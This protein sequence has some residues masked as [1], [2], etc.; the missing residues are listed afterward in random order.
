MGERAT[1]GVLGAE[2]LRGAVDVLRAIE[3]LPSDATGVMGFGERGTIL[4][5]AGRICWAVAPGM[6]R[7]LTELLRQQRN[8]PI[9]RSLLRQL[10][11]QCERTKQP[12]GE[13]LLAGGHITE[14]GLRAALFRQTE[15]AIAHIGL[16]G[17][18]RPRFIP[19]TKAGY[20]PR[21][22]YSTSEILVA[23]GARN[24][25]AHAKVAQQHLV[26]FAGRSDAAFAFLRGDPPSVVACLSA[27]HLTTRELLTISRWVISTF[28]VS[29]IAAEE[30]GLVTCRWGRSTS[31]VCWRVRE[32]YYVALC[33]SR[34]PLALITTRLLDEVI[35]REGPS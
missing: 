30:P 18:R 31:V 4:V 27:A 2:A 23:L 32:T 16:A 5:E 33:T 13:A 15:E 9:D 24:D 22:R 19:H 28:D 8:P 11:H 17:A 10:V 21:F 35:V 1:A 26:A 14:A 7:R 29:S 3:G 6:G 34:A 25:R 12:L 20:D